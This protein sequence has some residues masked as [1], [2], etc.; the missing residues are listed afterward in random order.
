MLA[1]LEITLTEDESALSGLDK[2]KK[3]FDKWINAAET[4]LEMIIIKLPSPVKAQQ[5]RT[6]YL[7]QGPI[8]D[9]CGKSMK[10]CDPNGTLMVFITQMVSCE[11]RNYAFGRVFSGTARSGQ[12]VRIMGQKYTPGEN[13][14]LFQATVMRTVTIMRGRIEPVEAVP[15]GNLVLLLGIPIQAIK[16]S[17]ISDS[18]IGSTF[19]LMTFSQQPV[20]KVNVEPVS[21]RDLFKLHEA[22]KRLE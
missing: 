18:V 16:Q 20:V 10:N 12:K 14:D 22:F 3:I 11:G 13:T 4:L 5:Y 15:C 17:T 1:T 6:A 19:R 2:M 7:Y 21:E 8:D 9:P